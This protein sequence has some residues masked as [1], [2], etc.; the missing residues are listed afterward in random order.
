MEKYGHTSSLY[1]CSYRCISVVFISFRWYVYLAL[2]WNLFYHRGFLYEVLATNEG[3]SLI[4]EA[5]DWGCFFYSLWK[6]DRL[7]LN[8]SPW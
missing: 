7:Q 1:H 3:E 5:T 8:S 6:F 4:D 2:P